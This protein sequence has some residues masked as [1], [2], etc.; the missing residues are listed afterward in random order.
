MQQLTTFSYSASA[1]DPDGDVVSYSWNVSGA[2]FTGSSGTLFFISGGN[3]TATL[4][5]T[6]SRG[7]SATDSRTFAVGSVTGRWTGTFDI[8]NFVSN[9]TQNSTVLTGDYSDQAGVGRL[10]TAVANTVDA[11]G[12]VRLRYEQGAVSDFTFTG[13]MDTTGRR[14]TG[15]VN[16]SGYV[17]RPFTMNK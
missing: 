6:D 4:T 1:T 17:N 14:I 3:G 12:N 16:G 11:N 8:W 5:V 15:V 2:A 7:L 10:D 9:L 13:T